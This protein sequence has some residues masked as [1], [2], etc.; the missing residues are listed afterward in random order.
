MSDVITVG[1]TSSEHPLA[2]NESRCTLAALLFGLRFDA[3]NDA[4][5][6]LITPST[7]ELPDKSISIDAA[8]IRDA[9]FAPVSTIVH[10]DAN[11][12]AQSSSPCREQSGDV[13]TI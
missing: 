13:L 12:V 4:S 9:T 11:P 7:V 10:T 3:I 8:T 5:T 2:F 6:T 1:S